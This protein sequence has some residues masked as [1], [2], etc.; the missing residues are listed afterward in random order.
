M[1]SVSD[2]EVMLTPEERAERLQAVHGVI[3]L[4]RPVVQQD[5][6][7]LALIGADVETGVIDVQLQGSCSSCAVSSTTLQAGVTRIM[8]DRLPWVTVVNGG[9]QEMD[10]ELSESMGR[11]GYVP[12]RS[13]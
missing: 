9:V 6:G 3:E 7:D 1:S 10:E 5:G 12:R 2:V 4:L 8:K 13:Y 11:G